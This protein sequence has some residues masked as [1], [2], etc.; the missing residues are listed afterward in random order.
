MAAAASRDAISVPSEYKAWVTDSA[1]VLKFDPNVAVLKLRK[2]RCCSRCGEWVFAW[3][4][5][6]EIIERDLVSWNSMIFEYCKMGCA[7]DA[8][9]LF[10]EMKGDGFKPNETTLVNVPKRAGTWGI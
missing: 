7:G 6:D 8:V 9:G 3:K 2:M 1:D 10:R 5:F 4:V